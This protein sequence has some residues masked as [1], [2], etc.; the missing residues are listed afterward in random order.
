MA[1]KAATLEQVKMA[2]A[3]GEAA[4]RLVPRVGHL[5]ISLDHAPWHWL[6]ASEEPIVVQGLPS[7][8]HQLTLKLADANHQIMAVQH[9]AF[10][11]P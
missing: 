4:S 6:Q 9:I 3:Y 5:H 2:A 8:P 7:G 1:V 11:I 10:T